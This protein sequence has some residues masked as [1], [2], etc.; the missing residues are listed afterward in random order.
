MKKTIAVLAKWMP[1]GTDIF[2]FLL[3]LINFVSGYYFHPYS[4]WGYCLFGL[5]LSL[6][7]LGC[8]KKDKTE[9]DDKV[10]HVGCGLMLY[11]AAFWSV[12]LSFVINIYLAAFF[13][14]LQIAIAYYI[15][16]KYTRETTFRTLSFG[17]GSSVMIF[18]VIFLFA[19]MVAKRD[20]SV[21]EKYFHDEKGR[22]SVECI[23]KHSKDDEYQISYTAYKS[24]AN[25]FLGRFYSSEGV[26]IKSEKIPKNEYVKADIKW[27]DD[28][29]IIIN[30]KE[31]YV[32]FDY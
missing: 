27:K 25:L 1:L 9:Q 15:F 21:K 24:S 31:Y 12:S 14:A 3:G 26:S 5:A 18:V 13:G 28:E 11:A 23:V 30:E 6:I 17:L 4:E 10:Q 29:H 8:L 32:S 16:I 20:L 7:M 2:Y 19:P 22:L